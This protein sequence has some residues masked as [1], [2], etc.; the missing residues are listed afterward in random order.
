MATLPSTVDPAPR[1]RVAATVQVPA[2]R[3]GGSVGSW[4]GERMGLRGIAYQIG[5]AH[6]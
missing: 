4:L 6:V 5:R 3:T 2:I 1:S